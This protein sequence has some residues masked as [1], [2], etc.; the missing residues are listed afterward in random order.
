[1]K[2]AEVLGIATAPTAPYVLRHP[3]QDHHIVDG[4][5]YAPLLTLWVQ[6]L[7]RRSVAQLFHNFLLDPK[8][9]LAVV[10]ADEYDRSFHHLRPWVAVITSTDPDHLDIYGTEEAYLESFAHFTEL[11]KPEVLCSFTR[12]SRCARV[13]LRSEG[14]DLFANLGRF[15]MREHMPRRR[16]L[17]FDLVTPS[18]LI[19]K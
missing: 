2:R 3:R 15:Q 8:S 7:F 9:D 19:P 14:D 5:S 13:P 18:G 16:T 4:R 6:R 12:G 1:M 17:T 11:I 10:E